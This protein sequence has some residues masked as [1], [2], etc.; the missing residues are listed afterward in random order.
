MSG[1]R[2][3]HTVGLMTLAIA[4]II[5]GCNDQAASTPPPQDVTDLVVI[6]PHAVPIREAF[7]DGFRR[8]QT[9]HHIEPPIT[10]RWISHG[11]LECQRYILDRFG[12]QREADE[13]GIGVDVFFG[14][15]LAVHQSLAAQGLAHPVKV[16]DATLAAIPKDL[17]GQPLRAP[18]GSWYGTALGG[19]GILFNAVACRARDVPVPTTWVD[20]ASPAFAGW[21][22]AADPAQS[23][24][25]TQCLALILLKH[26]W[27]E[28]WGIVSG[29]LANSNGLFSA[30]ANIAPTVEAGIALA[31]LEPEFVARRSIAA[32]KGTMEYVNPPGATAIIPDPVTVLKGAKEP[33]AAAQFVEFV[34]SFEGQAL[35]ALP[36]DAAG[37]PPGEALY[38][39]PIRPDVYQKLDG[40]LL[41]K[42]NPFSEQAGLRVDPA[43]E[44]AYTALLPHLIRAACGPNHLALQKAWRQAAASPGQPAQL[45]TLKTP[46]FAKEQALQYASLCSQDPHQ[47][48]ELEAQ[49]SKLFED[50]YRAVLENAPQ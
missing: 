28:G 17:N 42:G 22:A 30:S 33:I 10:V 43:D 37:G 29:L 19:Y 5:A 13:A 6:T 35:W 39:Y 24:S 44:R 25:T 47:A 15:G 46:P 27:V 16:P 7:A 31:G 26:G 50:R 34:L 41:V 11:T 3:T 36:A 20:L 23:G 49:W 2:F 32:S 14:G 40:Q 21:V 9:A 12:E 48:G 1:V 8:W 38:R 45:Q 18:D 4:E